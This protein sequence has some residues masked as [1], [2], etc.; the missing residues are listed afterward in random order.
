[1]A[2]LEE[3][4]AADWANMDLLHAHRAARDELQAQLARWEELFD[5]SQTTV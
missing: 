1:V 3:K 4:L 5:E 2:S